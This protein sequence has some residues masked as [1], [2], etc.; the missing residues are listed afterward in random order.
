M[1][2]ILE[3]C[4]GM[5]NKR[6]CVLHSLSSKKERN[7]KEWK[8]GYRRYRSLYRIGSGSATAV[9][10]FIVLCVLYSH[11][12]LRIPNEPTFLIG[13]RGQC[14]NLPGQ[15]PVDYTDLLHNCLSFRY[16]RQI[17]L[18]FF[19][20]PCFTFILFF[21][22]CF[23]LFFWI[24]FSIEWQYNF[25]P[26]YIECHH[27]QYRVGEP[28]YSTKR[29]LFFPQFVDGMQRATC[30]LVNRV[31]V[32]PRVVVIPTHCSWINQSLLFSSV[33]HNA[34]SAQHVIMWGYYFFASLFTDKMGQHHLMGYLI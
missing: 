23:L 26:N 33:P 29:H 16:I 27:Q 8:S 30:H 24:S 31:A 34:A 14:R 20:R 5:Y 13:G 9:R 21:W 11:W 12:R 2:E 4:D 10:A 7:K 28:F 25:D 1:K 18:F 32:S 22:F 15:L 19:F 3:K 17:T 6:K